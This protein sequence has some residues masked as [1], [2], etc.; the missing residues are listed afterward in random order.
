[1]NWRSQPIGG[2]SVAEAHHL[3]GVRMNVEDQLPQSPGDGPQ[4]RPGDV[5]QLIDVPNRVFPLIASAT[6]EEDSMTSDVAGRSWRHGVEDPTEGERQIGTLVGPRG[7]ARS[8]LT[9]RKMKA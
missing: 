2:S 4:V 9:K 3:H 6:G 5:H 7:G 1:M 8:Q